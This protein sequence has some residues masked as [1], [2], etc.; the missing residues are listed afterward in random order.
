[1]VRIVIA[2]DS[3]KGSRSAGEVAAAIEEGIRRVFPAAEVRKV[4]LADGGEGTVRALVEATG[5]KIREAEVTGPLGETVKANYGILGE[6]RTAVIEMAAASGL[7][8]VPESKRDPSRTTTYGTGE[9]IKFALREGCRELIIGIGGSATTDGGAGMAQAL[10]ARL[11]DERG[12][13]IGFGGGELQRL[14][15][16]DLTHLDRR[17]KES[18]VTVASDVDNPLCGERGAAY[19]YGPQKGA[20]PE[21]V[22]K[23]D[24]ALRHFAGILKRDLH[25][26][27]ADIQGAGAA[28]GLGAGLI[29]FLEATL[30]PGIEI[31]LEAV[32]LEKK[33]LAADLVIT[34]E[35]KMDKQ[36]LYGK[37]PYGVAKLAGK[38]KKRVIAIC[39]MLGEGAEVLYQH[40]FQALFSN[41]KGSMSREEAM[42]RA[43]ELTVETTERAL[44]GLKIL[45]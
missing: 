18:K 41:R 38:H 24:E 15:R 30:R 11:R 39:G 28:G 3:F 10:G 17:I 35:G 29:A 2:P 27:V 32:G 9:L 19:V 40:G 5:G 34:G 23:L 36:T 25:K 7:P 26:D 14:D 6:G 42:R 43:K 8:L 45:S 22:K 13:E 33:I 37:A 4:P 20:T 21:M 16:I 31:V 44:R 12:K 1:M